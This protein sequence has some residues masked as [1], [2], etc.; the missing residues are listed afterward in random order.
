MYDTY[1]QKILAFYIYYRRMP[2]YSE[3]LALTGLSSKNSVHKLVNK[4]VDEGFLDKDRHGHLIPNRIYG[5][6]RVLGLIEAG[7][8]TPAEEETLDTM[9]LDDYLI[10]NKEATYMLQ[11]KGDSMIEA[12][13]CEGDMVIAERTTAAKEG[14]IIVAEVD[15]GWTMKYL[16]K[17]AGKYYLEPA[18]KKYK[19][20]YPTEELKIGAVV[21]GVIRKY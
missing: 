21:R 12:G 14:D 8:P 10:E 19:N 4:L 9:S 5:S 7:F 6:V 18:N 13:I 1:K 11:V 15:G 3:I 17:E 20:I 2:T 16:R